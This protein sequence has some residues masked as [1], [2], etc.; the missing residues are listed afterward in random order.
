MIE[1]Q[2]FCKAQ[3][4]PIQISFPIQL[5]TILDLFEMWHFNSFHVL[6]EDQNTAFV[7]VPPFAS[8]INF[9]GLDSPENG[10]KFTFEGP[11]FYIPI[12]SPWL[13]TSKYVMTFAGIVKAKNNY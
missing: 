8:N 12:S 11:C 10:G 2:V 3:R 1:L 6:L 9:Q 13:K 5:C 7:S 4:F